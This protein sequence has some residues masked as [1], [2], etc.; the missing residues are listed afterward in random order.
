MEQCLLLYL[1][2]V[3][4]EKGALGSPSTKAANFTNLCGAFNNFPD[5]F[6]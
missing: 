4:F 5:F 2:V 6:V 1:G 3:A